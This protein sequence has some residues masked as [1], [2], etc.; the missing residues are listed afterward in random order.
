MTS[1]RTEPTAID[2]LTQEL[3]E[4]EW[5]GRSSAPEV[6]PEPSVTDWLLALAGAL[7][8]PLPA[9]VP[10]SGRSGVG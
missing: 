4:V 6:A 8:D 2:A 10:S 3:S 5:F 9:L 1:S 7:R